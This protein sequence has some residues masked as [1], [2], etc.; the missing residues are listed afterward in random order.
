M[1]HVTER[2][3]LHSNSFSANWYTIL[4]VGTANFTIGCL[5]YIDVRRIASIISRYKE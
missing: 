4:L 1:P 3:S 5:V 2:H